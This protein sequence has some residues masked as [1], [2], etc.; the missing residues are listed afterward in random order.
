MYEGDK[1]SIILSP[2]LFVNSL[3]GD[4]Y[5]GRFTYKVK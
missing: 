4:G 1:Y 5:N 3:K 2:L